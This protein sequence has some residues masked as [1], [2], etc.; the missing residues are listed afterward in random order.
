M[1]LNNFENEINVFDYGLSNESKEVF[2]ETGIK[3]NRGSK[4][5]KEA[6]KEKILVKPLDKVFSVKNK[7]CFVKVDVE[8]HEKEVVLGSISFL[9][10]NRCFIQAEISHEHDFQHFDKI[11]TDLGY[12]LIHRI[13]DYYY[14]NIN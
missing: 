2:F 1:F 6:G 5:I 4:S 8:G 12:N 3:E 9:K 7:I 11:M 10:N 13:N 14:S